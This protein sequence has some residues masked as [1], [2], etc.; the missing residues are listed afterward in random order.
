[1]NF[2]VLPKT[3]QFMIFRPEVLHESNGSKG[4]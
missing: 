1:M 3:S 2:F 4:L